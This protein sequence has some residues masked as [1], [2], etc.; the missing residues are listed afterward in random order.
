MSHSHLYLTCEH[1]G[2]RV[3]RGFAPLF[4]HWSHLLNSHRGWDPGAAELAACLA[5]SQGCPAESSGVTRLLVDLNRSIGSRT[6]FSEVTRGLG[7]V[8]KEHILREYY[9]PFRNRVS[10]DV[11]SLL[12]S[13]SVTH[14]S[15]HSFVPV[16]QGRRRETDVG[17][18]F[19]PGRKE[20]QEFARW[21]KD[22]IERVL[23]ELRVRFNYPYRG[24]ADGHVTALRRRYPEN[25]RGVELEVNQGLAE[26]QKVWQRVMVSLARSLHGVLDWRGEDR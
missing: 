26:E 8:E 17:I 15:I 5:K 2:N 16:L 20:E 14:I 12:K 9:F 1:A 18:L 13:G 3:P 7:R 22:A 10:E 23:P 6:L 24:T 21:W 19:D 25:Y 11:A 4:S